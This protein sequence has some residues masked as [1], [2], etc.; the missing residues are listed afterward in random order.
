MPV[1]FSFQQVREDIR[2]YTGD[3]TDEQVWRQLDGLPPLGFHLRHIAGSVDRLVT[4]LSGEQL[5][6]QQLLFL[7]QEATA[8][9]TLQELLRAVDASLDVAEA[10][11]RN[12]NPQTVYDARSVGRRKLPTTVV[13]LLIHLAEHTQRHLGQAITTAKFLKHMS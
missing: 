2:T 9:A 1:L 10:R 3:L 4:Y 7:R 12:I 13:G 6:E 8:G 11:V 5:S